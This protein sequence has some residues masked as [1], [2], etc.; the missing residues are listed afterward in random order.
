M[1]RLSL[2]CGE[3]DEL[4]LALESGTDEAPE[5]SVE[6]LELSA[7]H[8]SPSGSVVL[9]GSP[10]QFIQVLGRSFR[11]SAGSFF[12]VNTPAA[13]KLVAHVLECLPLDPGQLVIDAYC[14]V[15]LFSAIPGIA[16]ARLVGIESSPA[17]CD[18]FAWNLDEFDDV[19]LYEA[20]VE[21]VLPALEERPAAVVLD[22]PRGGLTPKGIDELLR[23]E[24]PRLV[25]VS[26]DPATLAHDTR[27][28]LAGGYR[29]E[30]V[31]PFDLFPQTYHI[32]SV[33]VFWRSSKTRQVD[34]KKS[35]VIQNKTTITTFF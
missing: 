11:V 6:E 12:Q 17:A 27:R 23:L 3:G 31:T 2:R 4:L 30:R 8:L 13:E 32:E 21:D 19:A 25:Y 16:G 26:C 1:Q 10:Y 35:Q 34:L 5:V 24:A 20:A 22:P 28:L 29:L 18:D 15:G 7:V 14:G 9:A 33:S